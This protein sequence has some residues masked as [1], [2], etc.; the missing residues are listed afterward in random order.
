MVLPAS[1]AS[2]Q[3]KV[4]SSF[5]IQ[6]GRG[7]RGGQ[8]D[9]GLGLGEQFPPGNEM[10]VLSSPLSEGGGGGGCGGGGGVGGGVGRGRWGGNI[11][12]RRLWFPFPRGRSSQRE[13]P[14]N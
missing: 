4:E 3:K 9:K 12:S 11:R 5:L 1:A 2:I 8:T 7:E 6:S 14:S 13:R 10:R